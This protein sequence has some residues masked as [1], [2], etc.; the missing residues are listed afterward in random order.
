[1]QTQNN[2]S[3]PFQRSIHTHKYN[4]L[5][6]NDPF[7]IVAVFLLLWIPPKTRICLLSIMMMRISNKTCT[8]ILLFYIC[9]LCGIYRVYI[10]YCIYTVHIGVCVFTNVLIVCYDLYK[11]S[12]HFFF[13]FW[14]KFWIIILCHWHRFV[15]VVMG[16]SGISLYNLHTHSS[17]HCMVIDGIT[18][19]M[20]VLSLTKKKY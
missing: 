2:E 8:F 3:S 1:M 15:Y 5:C 17:K 16:S 9:A 18:E 20:C 12:Q 14:R 4:Q 7:N 11:C 13:F 19:W 10:A 6:F